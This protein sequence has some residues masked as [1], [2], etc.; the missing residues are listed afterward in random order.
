M[1][2]RCQMGV[3]LAYNHCIIVPCIGILPKELVQRCTIVKQ[4]RSQS[5]RI[6]DIGADVA[7]V[8]GYK[9]V[10]TYAPSS[11]LAMMRYQL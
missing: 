4:S 6:K 10:H 7:V 5:N 8:I 1:P 2:R 9:Y 11:K 3:V